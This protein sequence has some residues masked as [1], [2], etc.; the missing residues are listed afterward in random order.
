V[1]KW[2][3]ENV[4]IAFDVMAILLIMVNH[5]GCHLNL[6]RNFDNIHYQWECTAYSYF[7]SYCI[8]VFK[9]CEVFWMILTN[10]GRHAMS[11]VKYYLEKLH[12]LMY[13]VMVGHWKP[14]L[15]IRLDDRLWARSIHPL[16]SGCIASSYIYMHIIYGIWHM[17]NWKTTKDCWSMNIVWYYV[18]KTIWYEVGA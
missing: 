18:W 15:L 17:Y 4:N 2:Y 6:K 8:I 13:V 12:C 5:V 11:F 3:V 16:P 9:W 7:F 14:Q 1:W 10:Y